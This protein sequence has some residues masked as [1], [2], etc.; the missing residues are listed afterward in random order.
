MEILINNPLTQ[1]IIGLVVGFYIDKI[2]RRFFVELAKRPEFQALA[3][4][5]FVVAEKT[6]FKENGEFKGKF[7]TAYVKNKIPGK[8]DDIAI[9]LAL[10]TIYESLPKSK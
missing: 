8:I 5:A 1:G 6:C 7:A 9:D 2:R 4:E 3:H 10:K